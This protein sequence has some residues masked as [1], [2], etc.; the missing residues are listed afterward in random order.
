MSVLIV[1]LI[2]RRGNIREDINSMRGITEKYHLR[3]EL[4]RE[5]VRLYVKQFPHEYRS[6]LLEIKK[7]RATRANK[8]AAEVNDRGKIPWDNDPMR[9]VLRIPARLDDL[10]NGFL[11]LDVEPR[12]CQENDEVLWFGREFLQFRVPETL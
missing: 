11:K 7:L 6:V 3:K 5:C 9:L 4:I 8:F 1:L 10:V 12:F 2:L